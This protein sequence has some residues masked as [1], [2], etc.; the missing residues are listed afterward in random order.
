MKALSD[1][2]F[3]PC[4]CVYELHAEFNSLTSVANQERKNQAETGASEETPEAQLNEPGVPADFYLKN[5]TLL[6]DKHPQVQHW[7]L[8][9]LGIHTQNKKTPNITWL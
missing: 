3:L 4:K 2:Y 6:K 9:A 8:Q 5:T 7:I 1:E